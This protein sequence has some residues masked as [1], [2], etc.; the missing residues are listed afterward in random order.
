VVSRRG[1]ITGGAASWAAAGAAGFLAPIAAR[2][3]SPP[4]FTSDP[5]G[6][7]IASGDPSADSVVL[8]TRLCP[9]PFDPDGLGDAAYE[10]TWELAADEGFRRILRTGRRLATPERAHAVHVELSG[11]QADR[12]Y[13]YRFSV[14]GALSPVGRTSTLPMIGAPRDR[15]KLAWASCQHYEQGLFTAYRDLIAWDPRFVLHVG[16]Y[17]YEV[18]YGPQLRR[19]PVGDPWTLA[20]YRL[21]H[22][23]YKLDPDLQ[24]A[25][26]HCAWAFIWDDHEVSN[27]YAGLDPSNPAH[28]A[29]FAARRAAA[30]QAY[31]EH[32]PI[33]RRAVAGANGVRLY[34][35]LAYG[36][37]VDLMMLDTRQYRSP[38]A[39]VDA[40]RFTSR[41]VSCPELTA[42][43]RT[44]LGGEQETWLARAL[45]QDPAEWTLL[46]QTTLFSRL[47]QS[48]PNGEQLG[49]QDDWDGYPAA[50]QAL[51]DRVV[52]S[53]VKNPVFLGGDVHSYW[54]CDVKANFGRPDSPVIASEFVGTSVTSKSYGYDTYRRMIDTG[55]NGHVRFYDDRRRGY[56]RLDIRRDRC[57]VEF[58]AVDSTWTQT[59]QFSTLQAFTVAAGKPGVQLA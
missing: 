23:V 31:L 42:A 56:G 49:F 5:F 41:G 32:M 17:I 16:D 24:A 18:S 54:A 29:G 51:L 30:Y 6:L 39:C 21:Q 13:W 47:Q 46:V 55:D 7:G 59:P 37:L 12:E 33:S 26:R 27:D 11:L 36:D 44:V 10:V 22:A 50:R 52:Q 58:R 34:Q 15:L 57:D 8:W 25:H 20:D 28:K 1:L 9:D 48:G 38:R 40:A 14:G 3:A 43:G 4:R 35:R 53:K 2:A 45:V 19:H